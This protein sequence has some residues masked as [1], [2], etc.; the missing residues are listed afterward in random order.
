VTGTAFVSGYAPV[1]GL[2]IYY[3]IHGAGDPLVL[4]H[5]G[6]G[7]TAMFEHLIPILAASNQVIA[8]DLQAHGRTADVDRPLRY[9]QMA[10]D[11]AGVLG[12]LRIRNAAFMGYSLGAGVAHMG[13]ATAEAMKQSPLYQVYAS[14]APRPEDWPVL[15]SKLPDLLALE[16]DWSGDIAAIEAPTLLVFADADSIRPS[17]MVEFYK[18]LGGGR[19]DGGWDGSGVPSSRLAVLPGRTHYDIMESPLLGTLVHTFLDG[20]GAR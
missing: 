7:S 15:H 20:A 16:Y 6:M 17:H 18:L 14:V 19:R 2:K 1:N 12:S 11:I 5:G 4:L 8:I 9:E 10:D 3:E 13:P